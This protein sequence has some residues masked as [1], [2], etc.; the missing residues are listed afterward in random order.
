MDD[1][2]GRAFAEALGRKDATRLKALLHPDVNFKAMTPGRF[3]Q[4][5]SSDEVVDEVLLLVAVCLLPLVNWRAL[6]QRRS[7][8]HP[9]DRAE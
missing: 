8:S 6:L 3:W 9:R 7:N 4:A 5:D 2:L 1:G